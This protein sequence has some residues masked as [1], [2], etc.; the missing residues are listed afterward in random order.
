MELTAADIES[1]VINLGVVNNY[2]PMVPIQ[3]QF[4]SVEFTKVDAAGNPLPGAQF[5][6]RREVPEV[7]NSETGE[8]EFP[9]RTIVYR[10]QAAADGLVSFPRVEPGAGYTLVETSAPRNFAASVVIP[11]ISVKGRQTSYLAD[12]ENKVAN[13]LAEVELRKLGVTHD[14]LEG[15]EFGQLQAIDGSPLAGATFELFRGTE[16]QG[17]FTTDAAGSVLLTD[18][19][20]PRRNNPARRLRASRRPGHDL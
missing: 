12:A 3:P 19:E 8:V 1:R 5:E 13:T 7:L 2:R 4:G 11:D 20:P 17:F 6:L 15:R 16:S 9:A 10:A 18:L 14:R